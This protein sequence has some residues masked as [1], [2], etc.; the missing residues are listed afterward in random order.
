M[1]VA[2]GAAVWLLLLEWWLRH[3]ALDGLHFSILTS[4]DLVHTLPL[5]ALRAE[6]LQSLWWAHAYP[7]GLD[8]IRLPFVWWLRDESLPALLQ[9]LDRILLVL[10]ACQFGAIAAGV[11]TWLADLSGRRVA[12][13]GTALW[14]L[15]PAALTYGTLLDSTQLTAWLLLLLVRHLWHLSRD[16]QASISRVGWTQLVL[17]AFRALVQWPFMLVTA[18]AMLLLGVCP[19]RVVRLT[20]IC[21]LV[22]LAWLVKQYVQVGW[23]S[24]STAV[25]SN[26]AR[27]IGEP[28]GFD[29][30]FELETEEIDAV[31]D[32]PLVLTLPHKVGG[33][34]NHN[35]RAFIERHREQLDE[36]LEAWRG[37]TWGRLWS[38]YR[39]NFGMFLGS[40]R[41]YLQ[42]VLITA[43]PAWW[44]SPYELPLTRVP[45]LA[46]TAAALWWY[47]RRTLLTV[48][49]WR[50]TVAILLPVSV[51]VLL[52]IVGERGENM[53]FRYFIEPIWW[54]FLVSQAADALSVCYQ[55]LSDSSP[56]ETA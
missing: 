36:F 13:I 12:A 15:H 4:E 30:H 51:V 28:E 43:L 23:L 39:A 41:T 29:G 46:I 54:V 1:L 27:S 38:E 31:A 56:A 21:L 53:R 22:A 37:A 32:G 18:A 2:V 20:A 25:G 26:L 50:H 49:R 24:T 7:P 9:Q 3:A 34:F 6:P 40:H 16:P 33:E 14:V 8:L 52:S 47:Q 42:N 10:W 48:R 17:L 11:F 44:T 55:R 45:L 35:H 5:E 19:R